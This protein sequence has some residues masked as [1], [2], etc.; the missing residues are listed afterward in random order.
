M[1]FTRSNMAH[2]RVWVSNQPFSRLLLYWIIIYFSVGLIF[3]LVYLLGHD[4]A[5]SSPCWMGALLSSLYFSLTTLSTLGYG[6][7]APVGVGRIF[8]VIEAFLGISLNAIVLGIVVFK[9]LRRSLPLELSDLLYD[10]SNRYFRLRF[11]NVDADRLRDITMTWT[12]IKKLTLRE[13]DETHT[14]YDTIATPIPADLKSWTVTYPFRIMGLKSLQH[15]DIVNCEK[16]VLSDHLASDAVSPEIFFRGIDIAKSFE[17]F[18]EVSGS[19]YFESTGEQFF[20]T[21]IYEVGDIKCGR[22]TRMS[23]NDLELIPNV[24]DRLKSLDRIFT[25]V[26]LT[27]ENQCK[28][29]GFFSHCRF[30]R[31]VTLKTKTED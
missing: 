4:P 26:D 14:Y 28:K 7:L 8:S 25:K 15:P 24:K 22:F 20:F 19:G 1:R 3:S 6:D 13:A 9:A 31:A 17:V 16:S 11:V 29:C 23:N 27:P 12:A 10:Q 18:I 21:K 30:S 5:I 2:F